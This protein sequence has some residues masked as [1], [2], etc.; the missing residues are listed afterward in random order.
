[1]IIGLPTFTLFHVVLSLLGIVGQVVVGGLMAGVRLDRWTAVYFV[2][3]VS[4]N[5]TG[6]FFP[7]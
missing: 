5:V 6:F 4:T 2:A 1:M 7:S 3:T